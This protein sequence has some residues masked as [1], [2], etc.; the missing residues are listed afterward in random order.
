MGP[1]LMNN[2]QTDIY[3]FYKSDGVK[4]YSK[5]DAMCLGPP[6][7]T[8]WHYNDHFFSSFDWKKPSMM[9]LS[10]LYRRRAEQLRNDYDYLILMYSGGSDSDNI[11]DTFVTNNIHLDEVCHNVI[12][13]SVGLYNDEINNIAAIKTKSYIDKYKLKT[14]QRFFDIAPTLINFFDNKE[15]HDFIHWA[16]IP[17][18]VTYTKPKAGTI[19]DSGIR[20]WQEL[21]TSGKKI[22]VIH[23]FD[24]PRLIKQ[25]D[26]LFFSFLDNVNHYCN[27]KDQQSSRISSYATDELFYWSPHV[28]CANIIIKQCNIIK[29]FIQN[30]GAV[31]F[32]RK[33][34]HKI[35]EKN[36]TV[37]S[38]GKLDYVIGDNILKDLIYPLWGD[39][40]DPLYQLK[41]SSLYN[42]KP[43]VANARDNWWFKS[44]GENTRRY[45]DYLRIMYKTINIDWFDHDK[46][47]N[48]MVIDGVSY[49][50]WFK[51]VH[52]KRYYL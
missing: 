15:N 46:N 49:P 26:R 45:L 21:A 3:G 34:R 22:G 31:Y 23:G 5:Y 28:N 41:R 9:P 17:N 38:N 25:D 10:E 19:L 16:N 14:I 43:T 13:N 52:S 42:D 1:P 27:I 40:S 29:D 44:S 6:S 2:D 51:K 47:K 36:V 39:V 35:S 32:L 18:F 30:Q 7:K 24:K 11:L 50:R 37:F 33:I 48:D 8:T 12:S 20:L 4:F